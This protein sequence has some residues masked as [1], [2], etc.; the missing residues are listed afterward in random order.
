M[1]EANTPEKTYGKLTES[2]VKE[3]IRDLRNG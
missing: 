2:E 3:I 1:L